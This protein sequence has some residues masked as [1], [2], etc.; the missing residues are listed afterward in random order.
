VRT[1]LNI[2]DV[3]LAE[4]KQRAAREG[5]KISAVVNDVLREDIAGRRAKTRHPRRIRLTTFC[6]DGVRP[7][8]H[9]DCMSELLDIMDGVS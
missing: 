9:L 3:L 6:G 5:R 7:G 1:T 8:V 2:D 4:V